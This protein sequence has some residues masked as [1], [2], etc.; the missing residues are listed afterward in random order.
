L[1]KL[2]KYTKV[3]ELKPGESLFGEEGGSVAES[4]RGFFFIEHGLMRVERNVA[5]RSRSALSLRTSFSA[6]NLSQ[7]PADSNSNISIGQ[8]NAR[9]ASVETIGHLHARAT[10]VGRK[11]AR[12][13]EARKSERG[14]QNFRLA[15]IGQGWVVGSIEGCSGMRNSGMHFAGKRLFVIIKMRLLATCNLTPVSCRSSF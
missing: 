4:D 14:V 15:R 13:K 8:L 12:I 6:T 3:V 11:D 1:E 10:T 5:Y 2:E 7:M 9:S